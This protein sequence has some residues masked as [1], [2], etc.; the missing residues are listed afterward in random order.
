MGCI[1]HVSC[2]LPDEVMNYPPLMNNRQRSCV[3]CLC[4]RLCLHLHF[5][6]S[7]PRNLF[8][9]QRP[10]SPGTPLQ[11]FCGLLFAAP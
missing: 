7:V 9:L 8:Q 6:L 2:F 11:I 10:D 1:S 4:L 5:D 3:Y